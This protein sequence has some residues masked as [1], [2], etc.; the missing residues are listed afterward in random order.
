MDLLVLD[1]ITDDAVIKSSYVRGI[2]SVTTVPTARS[3]GTPDPNKL[4]SPQSP[5]PGGMDRTNT[6]SSVNSLHPTTSAPQTIA[7][8]TVT[9]ASKDADKIVYP[10]KLKHLGREPYLL[11]APSAANRAEWG[12]KIVEAKTR[13]AKS[14]HAQNAEPFR[15]R[16]IADSAFYFDYSLTGVSIG[17]GVM[18]EGTPVYRAIK[19]VERKFKDSGRPGPI[20]RAKVNCAT[21]FTTPYPGKHMVAVGTDYGVFL[22]EIGNPRGWTRT[23]NVPRVTQIAVLEEFSLLLLISGGALIAYHLDVVCTSDKLNG[24]STGADSARNA[25]QK[26]SGSKDVG[27]FAIGQMKDRTLVFYKKRDG[28]SSTFKILEPVFQKSTEKKRGIFKRGTTEFFRD[29]DEFYIPTECTGINLFHSSMAV[30]TSRGFEVL[31]LDKKQTFSVPDLRAPEVSNIATHIEHQQTLGMLRVSDQEYLLCYEKCAVYV[32]RYGDVSRSVIMNFVGR[33]R[34][35]ALYG[36]YL[37]L[38]DADFVEV[39]NA[40]NGR[41]KQIIAGREIRCLDDGGGGTIS[42][43]SVNTGVVDGVP[44]LGV[45]SRTVKVV[46]QHPE[47][48]RTQIVVELVLNEGLKE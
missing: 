47:S 30:S 21:S 28:L 10:F 43:G 23:L 12:N 31:T 2:T 37:L 19:E 15:L 45:G 40:Q 33:A 46:M 29:Y 14:L 42:G 8:A 48:E 38:F 20:C 4:R 34:S 22:S 5:T 44:A 17:K 11:F 35:A 25:P 24:A 27:F 18:I 16:V 9:E 7:S 1:S 36:P 13:H 6:A 39:R 26:L 3:A 41:L 32:N